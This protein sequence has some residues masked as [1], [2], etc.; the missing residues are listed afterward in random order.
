MKL[1]C[2]C[3]AIVPLKRHWPRR[4]GWYG[5]CERCRLWYTN[6]QIGDFER[7]T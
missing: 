2:P 6:Q 4:K 7:V 5:Y 1:R 3:G